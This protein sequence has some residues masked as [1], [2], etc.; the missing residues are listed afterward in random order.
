MA[1]QVV[2][3]KFGKKI[4]ST[5]R[6]D[7]QTDSVTYSC[8]MLDD[9]SIIN[10][11]ISIAGADNT[12]NPSKY[13]YAFIASYDSRYYFVSDWTYSQGL[14]IA[15]LT[16]DVL[17]SWR[18]SI[19]TSSQYILR[20]QADSA[21][22]P[23]MSD[24]NYPTRS[25]YSC[26]N[27]YS[28]TNPFVTAI[29]DGSVVVGV[30]GKSP[31]NK[32]SV[33]AANYYAMTPQ[34][35]SIFLKTFLSSNDFLTQVVTG[36]INPIDYIVSCKWFPF[37][38]DF[39]PATEES[40]KITFGWWDIPTAITYKRVYGDNIVKTVNT[41][42]KLPL[43]SQNDEKGNWLNFSPFTRRSFIWPPIGIIPI[44]CSLLIPLSIG[45]KINVQYN[46]DLISGSAAYSF[47]SAGSIINSG[48]CAFGVDLAFA[49]STV[50]VG[51]IT[52]N[53]QSAM[54]N[55]AG[56]N[57]AGFVGNVINGVAQALPTFEKSGSVSSFAAFTSNKPYIRSDFIQLPETNTETFGRPSYKYLKI[58]DIPGYI[59]TGNAHLEIAATDN[60][61]DQIISYMN[62]GFYYE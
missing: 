22:N 62:G 55:I 47:Y 52:E 28:Q 18:G 39:F 31:D 58:S 11:K 36:I 10:P 61:I 49:Q 1:I 56:D 46:I 23:Q 16:E 37:S 44:D 40:T 20:A 3:Y 7:A 8:N 15:S 24:S 50:N 59:Q 2:F 42:Y 12:F 35:F 4:N 48:N 26:I 21:Y 13:N 60:E 30:V 57:Y 19:G 17:A 41:T 45:I 14:W 33:T 9:C 34:N 25:G 38:Y 6:P 51:A 32:V 27:T 29:S 53:A 43:H 5:K 54:L